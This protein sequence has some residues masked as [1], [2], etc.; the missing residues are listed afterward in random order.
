MQ[1]ER[2][3]DL[4]SGSEEGGC[5]MIQVARA[6][7]EASRCGESA[8]EQTRPPASFGRL[9][10]QLAPAGARR[11]RRR[12]AA[13]RRCLA[14]GAANVLRC[15]VLGVNGVPA[16]TSTRRLELP[17]VSRRSARKQ[18]F[19][20]VHLRR[21]RQRTVDSPASPTLSPE[22][23]PPRLASPVRQHKHKQQTAAVRCAISARSPIRPLDPRMIFPA[24]KR[25][26][27]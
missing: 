9:H 6:A 4:P 20:A 12:W 15:D 19:H 13:A 26:L 24:R 18:P 23:P 5:V 11:P 21:R 14:G 2:N 8:S 17:H 22:F 7:D 10:C 1:R 25:T 16:A 3:R 27:T